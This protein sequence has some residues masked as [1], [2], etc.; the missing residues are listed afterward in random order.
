MINSLEKNNVTSL[1]NFSAVASRFRNT[2]NNSLLN[3]QSLE[4]NRAG[5]PLEDAK[6]AY[7]STTKITA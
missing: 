1:S 4:C 2:S 3:E 5:S 7:R 6:A